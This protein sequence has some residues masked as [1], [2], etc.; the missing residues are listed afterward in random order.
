MESDNIPSVLKIAL[1]EIFSKKGKKGIYHWILPTLLGMRQE[2]LL[3]M[4]E[5]VLSDDMF[6]VDMGCNVGYLTRPFS[7][8]ANAIGLDVDKDKLHWQN[9]LTGRSTLFAVIYVTYC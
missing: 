9:N 7:L 2:Y 8:R 3:R 1:R 4:I 6:I 5:F